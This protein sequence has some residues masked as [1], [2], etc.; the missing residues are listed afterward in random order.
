MKT[1]RTCLTAAV[2]LHLVAGFSIAADLIVEENG[3][4]PNYATIQSAVNAANP[5]DRIFVKNKAGNVPYNETITI[6]RP[7][8]LLSHAPDGVFYVFGGYSIVPNSAMF[9]GPGGTIRIVGMYNLSGGVDASVNNG[10]GS[11]IEIAVV[12][13]TFVSGDV[14]L[15][16]TGYVSHVAGNH[17]MSGSV[18]TREGLVSGNQV[19][20]SITVNDAGTVTSGDDTMYVVGNRVCTAAGGFA[21]GGIVWNN[22]VH[23]LHLANNHVRSTAADLIVINN[24]HGGPLMNQI[25]NNSCETGTSATLNTG[26]RIGITVPSTARLLI[27][28]NALLDSF[29]GDDAGT[30]ECAI[31]FAAGVAAGAQ[32]DV[33]SNVHKDWETGLSNASAA[34]VSFAGNGTG[35]GAFNPNDI[36]GACTDASCINTGHPGTDHTDHDLTRNDV[37]TAGGSFNLNNFWPNQTGSARVYLVKTPRTVVQSSTINAKADSYD[38]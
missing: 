21:P 5:G 15:S 7:V 4:L 31:Q 2:S 22:P 24:L 16:G 38:R 28:S 10:S 19:V 12:N 23:Y 34:A 32:V 25:C 36:S 17:L 11:P 6:D 27:A 3:V 1:H 33:V 29:S 30:T 9:T 35:G 26:I 37:G 20:G 13:S 18:T 14:N 8:E